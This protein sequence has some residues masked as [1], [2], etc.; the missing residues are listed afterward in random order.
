MHR[1]RISNILE[2][3]EIDNKLHDKCVIQGVLNLDKREEY[4]NLFLIINIASFQIVLH[5]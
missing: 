2:Y 1:I 5:Y 3:G 4:L